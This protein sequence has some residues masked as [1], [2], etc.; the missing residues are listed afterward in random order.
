MDFGGEEVLGFLK[1]MAKHQE[2]V[3]SRHVQV[4]TATIQ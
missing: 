1:A 4:V 3:G 2:L